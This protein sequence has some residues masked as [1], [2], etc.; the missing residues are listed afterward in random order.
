M[1]LP[2]RP[3]VRFGHV[4]VL[5]AILAL[6]AVLLPPLRA[7]AGSLHVT[8]VAGHEVT[9]EAPATRLVLG[10][11]RHMTVLGL[12]H[13]DPVAR[14]AGWRLDKALDDVT[15]AAYRERFPAIDDLRP[16]GSGNRDLSVESIIA[17]D[18]D[19]V[20]LSLVDAR[21][22]GMGVARARLASAGIP[23]VHVDFFSHPLENAIPSLRILGTLTGAEARAEEFITFYEER[24]SRIRDRLAEAAP[25]RPRVFLH[26]H[27]QPTGCCSTAGQGIF[28]DFIEIAGGHNIGQDVLPGVAG[29][30]S[31]EYLLSADPDVYVAT[32]GTHLAARGGLTL[33]PGVSAAAAR[34]SFDTLLAARGIGALSAVQAGRSAGIWHLFN[35]SPVHIA[36]IEYLARLFHPELFGDVDPAAT[37]KEIDDRFSAV[38]VAGTWW[39]RAE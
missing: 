37:L 23:V 28:H 32:G 29:N 6:A 4:P 18:P 8:D 24:L 15:L 7:G 34:D 12:L 13:D 25:P 1:I 31:L 39:I 36:V 19:L 27:A 33:G 20:V 17:L 14:V 16:V 10:E 3:A 21:D 38:P 35:D 26:A 5:I 11:G 22:P 2:A 9:L 30:V